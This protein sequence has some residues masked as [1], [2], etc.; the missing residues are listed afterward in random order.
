MYLLL[1]STTSTHSEAYRCSENVDDNKIIW[2]TNWHGHW[3]VIS[4]F[5]YVVSWVWIP[6]HP[7]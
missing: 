6:A 2:K 7:G 5:I 3:T 1:L 4:L